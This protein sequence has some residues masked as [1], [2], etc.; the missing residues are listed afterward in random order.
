[1]R[2][3]GKNVEQ[4]ST[5]RTRQASVKQ[6]QANSQDY[7]DQEYDDVW[8]TRMPS[9]ARRYYSGEVS[10]GASYE[11]ADVEDVALSEYPSTRPGRKS[12][13]PARS[14]ATQTSLPLTQARR[15][16]TQAHMP[17]TQTR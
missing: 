5:Q 14:T 17:V 4:R 15:T 3:D 16:A 9:S 13:V 12:S 1:M 8:P 7:F 2:K 6:P 11:G 10:S